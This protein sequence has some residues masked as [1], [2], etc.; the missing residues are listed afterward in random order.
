MAWS[1]S[2]T[3]PADLAFAKDTL[4]K[5]FGGYFQGGP[6]TDFENRDSQPETLQE[7]LYAPK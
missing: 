1:R 3:S 4:G 2:A 7:K 5:L 6:N